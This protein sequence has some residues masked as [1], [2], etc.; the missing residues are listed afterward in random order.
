MRCLILGCSRTKNE[1]PEPLPAIERY[2][3]PPYKVL[4]R[5][6]DK[7]NSRNQSLDVYI[8]SAKYGLIDGSL[9]I[10]DYDER[11]TKERATIMR[12]QVLDQVQE[13]ILPQHYDEI[14][15]SMGIS[16]LQALAGL[17]EIVEGHT[18]VIASSGASGKKLTALRN[19]L[20][21]E[22]LPPTKSQQLELVSPNLV[23]QTVVLRG[24]AVMMNTEEAIHL[25]KSGIHND[26]ENAHDVRG[27]YVDVTG[28]KISPKWAAKTIFQM[29]VS[30]FSADEARRVLRR[31]GLNCYKQ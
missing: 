2:D 23:P 29:P 6:L 5:Y 3:G 24:S 25:L 10:E 11:M 20:W 12:D 21:G 30:Q 9:C 26:S 15:L 17:E 19:W 18:S 27:W 28:A 22:E 13:G 7:N 1:S 16:Y 8:L 31:L 4:R 14:F